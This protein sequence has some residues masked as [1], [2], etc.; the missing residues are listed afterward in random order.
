MPVTP[1]ECDAMSFD[2][3]RHQAI[4]L[5]E[6]RGDLKFLWGLVAHTQGATAMATEGGDLGGIGGSVSDAITAVHEV[7]S[8]YPNMSDL[9]PMLRVVFTDYLVKHS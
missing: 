9:E 6:H 1:A 2:D 7:F 8:D 5:A 4:S 3:L